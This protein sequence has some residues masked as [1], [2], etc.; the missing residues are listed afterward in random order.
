MKPQSAK[1]EID[2]VKQKIKQMRAVPVLMSLLSARAVQRIE[3][4][5]KKCFIAC[6]STIVAS[7][8]NLIKQLQYIL[9]LAG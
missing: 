9:G 7:A 5:F 8:C 2:F 1:L 6:S 3:F 4:D